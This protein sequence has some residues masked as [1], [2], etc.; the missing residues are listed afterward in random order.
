VQIGVI[1]RSF[2]P[3]SG[4]EQARK[5]EDHQLPSNELMRRATAKKP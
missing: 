3:V 1:D 2:L 5:F 4:V